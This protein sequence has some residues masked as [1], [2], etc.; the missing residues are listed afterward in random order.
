MGGTIFGECVECGKPAVYKRRRLCKKC[1]EGGI[2]M[3]IFDMFLIFVLIAGVS[4]ML[5]VFLSKYSKNTWFCKK[6]GWHL[7]PKVQGF[8]G[9]SL[10]GTCPRCKEKVMQDGQGN[11]F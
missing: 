6:M 5:M 10:N 9:C 2:E 11:W 3:S 1:V 8:D 4:F 7:P